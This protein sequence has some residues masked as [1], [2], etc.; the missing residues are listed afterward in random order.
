M[1]FDV[2]LSQLDFN[3]IGFSVLV[4]ADECAGGGLHAGFL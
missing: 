4:L 1:I 2:G 3:S